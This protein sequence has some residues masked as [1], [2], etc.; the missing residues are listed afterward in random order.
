LGQ[1]TGQVSL[2]TGDFDARLAQIAGRGLE[3]DVITT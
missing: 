1:A 3:P 2:F